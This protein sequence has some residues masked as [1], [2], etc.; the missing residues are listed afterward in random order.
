MN[1]KQVFRVL[2]DR[3]TTFL[4]S[5]NGEQT[6]TA[7]SSGNLK[8]SEH[9]FQPT[10]GD[11]VQ[12]TPQPG[13]WIYIDAVEPRKNLLARQ[14]VGGN[15][16]QKLGANIDFLFIATAVNQDFNLNR[17]DRYVAMALGC[18]IEPVI[19]LT[20]IDLTENPGDFI[21]QTAERF[22]ITDI[23]AVSAIENWNLEALQRY[24]QPEMTVALV[25][26]SGV[27]KSTL[28]NRLI[29][30]AVLDTG[31]IRED[32]GRG[33]H[34][35]THR[36]LHRLKEG[37]WLMDTPGLRSLALWDGEEGLSSLF[38]DIEAIAQRC[39]FTDCEHRTE[40][41]CQIQ[42]ALETGDLQ[43]ERWQ[44]FLKLQ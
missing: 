5:Q 8:K 9:Q 1:T 3:G 37:A 4:V 32:D 26:S 44:S 23:H 25:G 11:W 35:T 39:K 43:E 12:G 6:W 36:S 20:K 34:T 15:G 42:Q 7:E 41:G 24:L 27:G 30:T 18:G 13:D 16:L 40:P 28:A 38:Q 14:S 22:P 2:E 21:E 33:R 29:G 10:V 17:L 19:L 31:G